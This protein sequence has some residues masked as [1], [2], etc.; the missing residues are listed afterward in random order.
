M[1]GLGWSCVHMDLLLTVFVSFHRRSGPKWQHA[2]RQQRLRRWRNQSLTKIKEFFSRN[3]GYFSTSGKYVKAWT[4]RQTGPQDEISWHCTSDMNI[5]R[6]Y[7]NWTFFLPSA[8]TD[9]RILQILYKQIAHVNLYKKIQVNTVLFSWI[10]S[11]MELF[12]H[13]WQSNLQ[14][15]FIS[16]KSMSHW[17]LKLATIHTTTTAKRS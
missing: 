9:Y 15:S 8:H 13:S 7:L 10:L 14:K 2:L 11:T 16:N 6:G 1:F 3:I 4:S 5:F 12:W 17:S